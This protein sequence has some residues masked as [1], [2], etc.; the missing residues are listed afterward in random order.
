VNSQLDGRQR[1]RIVSQQHNKH[2]RLDGR[3]LMMCFQADRI[4]DEQQASMRVVVRKQRNK[5]PRL[6]GREML[7]RSSTTDA[8]LISKKSMCVRGSEV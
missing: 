2:A 7:M 8:M 5:H 4:N 1:Q 6:D 3:E